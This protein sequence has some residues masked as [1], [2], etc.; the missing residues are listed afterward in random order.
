MPDYSDWLQRKTTIGV[1]QTYYDSVIKIG[2]SYEPGV[3]SSNGFRYS[4]LK[5]RSTAIPRCYGLRYTRA[6]VG[7]GT[8]SLTTSIK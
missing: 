4:Y 1:S 8:I 2:S 3:L 7:D 5:Y 6:Y